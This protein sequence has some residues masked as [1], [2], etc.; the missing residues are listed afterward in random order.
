MRVNVKNIISAKKESLP[1]G[2]MYELVADVERNGRVRQG[3]KFTVSEDEYEQI[4]KNGYYD[5]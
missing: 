3:I 2:S 5:T 1:F 4:Q